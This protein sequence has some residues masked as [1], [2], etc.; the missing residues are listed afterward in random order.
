[1]SSP[2]S[3]AAGRDATENLERIAAVQRN[4]RALRARFVQRRTLDLFREE[5][6]SRGVVYF[7]RPD[8]FRWEVEEPA[9]VTMILRGDKILTRSA[10]ADEPYAMSLPPAGREIAAL[11]TGSVESAQR[12]FDARWAPGGNGGDRLVLRPR[13]PSLARTIRAVTLDLGPHG[14]HVQR[15][16]IEEAMG[17]RI[18]IGFSEV[19]INVT[20]ADELFTFDDAAA[21]E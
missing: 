20:I 7:K 4:V 13:Q 10:A 14:E 2:P 15:I 16:V 9:R 1:M 5:L 8:R 21:T 3:A 17:D 12:L 19:E 6:V 11:L 18:D